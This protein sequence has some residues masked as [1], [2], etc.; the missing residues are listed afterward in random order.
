MAAT[1]ERERVAHGP[2]A[3]KLFV[4]E[5]NNGVGKS[6]VARYLA[7]RLDAELFHFPPEFVRFRERAA[8]DTRV[9][10]VA[11]LLYYL[12]ATVELSEMVVAAQA[13]GH[14]VC[15]RYLAGPLSL[16]VADGSLAESDV[17]RLAAPLAG[18]LRSPA[19]TLLI[20]A[21]HAECRRRIGARPPDELTPV[22]KLTLESPQFF[23]ARHQALRRFAA[24]MGPVVE[25]ETTGAT[26]EE[27][28]PRAW[29]A[30][31]PFLD[32]RDA[33]VDRP[34]PPPARSME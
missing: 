8:L 19:L 1:N 18:G 22:Q 21:D 34:D 12:A 25:I 33:L 29:E 28:A 5:G 30:V 15:D 20:V 32:G 9:P 4:V 2:P 6:T 11:R 27:T 26:P 7:G 17:R 3:G 14:V 31:A 10:P 16:L 24:E 23:A 13:H